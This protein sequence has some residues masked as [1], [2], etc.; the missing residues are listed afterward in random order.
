[1]TRR[2]KEEMVAFLKDGLSRSRASF[3]IDV[4][5]LSVKQME[6]LRRKLRT[7]ASAEL[8]VA[9]NTLLDLAV[10]D[11][12]EYKP[13]K[14]Y[15]KN[16]LAIVFAN[17]D[18]LPVAK[19]LKQVSESAEQ[20]G[21]IAGVVENQVVRPEKIQFLASLPSRDQLLAKLCGAFKSPIASH[22]STLNQVVA[23]FVRV[24]DQVA[25]Q[26]AS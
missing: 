8:K 9:K 4:Q 23:Q 13:L 3:L 17:E 20:L 18:A 7:E 26:K 6:G 19:T 5:G 25:K 22:V 14:S 1:M 16:Q 10:E 12:E 11:F 21:V 15:F 24:V 2:E